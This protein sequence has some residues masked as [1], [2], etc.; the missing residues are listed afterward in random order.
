MMTTA[1][2]QPIKLTVMKYYFLFFYMSISITL[3]AQ[4]ENFTQ[5]VNPF[6]GT[7]GHGHTFPGATLPFAM[8][9]L[10]P[11]TRIDGSWDGCSG[12]HYD[13]SIIYGFSHT[14]LSG[15]GCSDYGDIAFLPI[16]STTKIDP[17]LLGASN[18]GVSY[19]H[20]NEKATAG[21]YEVLLNN[22]VKVALTSTLRAGIQKYSCPETGY[23]YI[24]LNLNHR[25][26]LLEGSIHEINSTSYSGI[27]RSKAW[28]NNQELYYYFQLSKAPLDH[29]IVQGKHGD[30]QLF[31]VY[32]VKKGD[33]ILIKTALSGVDEAGAKNNLEKEINDF[34][35]NKYIINASKQWN[36]ELSKIKVYESTREKKI[37]FYTAL[38]HCMIHPSIMN[39]IDNR[40]RGRDGK[41]HSTE[42]KFDY[43]SVFSL[44]DTYRALHPLLTVIDQKRSNDFIQTFIKQYEEGGRLPVWEL[45]GNETNCMIA[46][47][48]VSVIWDAYNKGIRDY[49]VSKAYQAM[50][51]IAMEQTDALVS[52]QKYGY[53]RADDDA[54]SVSKT[55]EYA[56]DDWCIAQMAKSLNKMDD[57]TYFME[58][59]S[60]WK[61]VYDPIS[62]FMRARKNGTMYEPFSPFMVDNN[63]TEANS[64]Q[65][66]FYVPQDLN[67]FNDLL[68]G[69][70]KL[71]QKLDELF[72]VSSTT[73]GRQQADITGLIGQYAHGNEPSHHI[74]YLYTNTSKRNNYIHYII[75][76]F[77]RNT[78]DGLIGNEDCGQMSAWYVWS[79]MGLYPVCPG[80]NE[81]SYSE[82]IFD[83]IKITMGKNNITLRKNKEVQ[84]FPPSS[85]INEN[86]QSEVE[87]MVPYIYPTQKI[88]KDS[89]IIKMGG[90]TS[91]YYSINQK[92]FELYTKELILKD[93]S[94]IQFYGLNNQVKSKMQEAIFYKLPNDKRVILN[95]TYN[96]QYHAGGAAGLIDGIHGNVNWRKGDW[97]GYQAQDFNAIIQ[98][99]TIQ[100]IQHVKST[101]LQDQRS[102]IFYPTSYEVY[103]SIDGKNYDL[104]YSKTYDIERADDKNSITLLDAEINS[105]CKFIKV[106][107]K[108]YGKLPSWHEGAGGDAFIF[109]DEIDAN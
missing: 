4:S 53:I 72:T 45:W 47:H 96:P 107:A 88:F 22:C 40:Y 41:I 20:E 32:E 49:D 38:Y 91:I 106:V 71:E 109:I 99:D 74:A 26:A 25:D 63:Y 108:N 42:G 30:E 9:Q 55:L 58:R 95:C 90:G 43:Y 14:H 28:A 33:M 65:Y 78:T 56:Y 97:Q 39:D 76:S 69:P 46:Y 35:F 66:S 8:V 62:G 84:L 48:A 34:D 100:K 86:K 73:E 6:I 50:K 87:A 51:S 75:D 21:Y 27:R 15:T 103:T 105:T 24:K 101:F 94:Y 102:W 5:Y 89:A 104:N 68:G 17:K 31:L 92:P 10:S 60:S 13:D 67:Q 52:Y 77:Y 29:K 85:L 1:Q 11:D 37:V 61:N 36:N 3:V 19:K 7:G 70:A 57:Y 98:L 79:A 18:Y 59:S 54:E 80:K 12:Y 2:L 93:K 82:S 44:W 23:L 81:L 16:F 83:S 64:Y